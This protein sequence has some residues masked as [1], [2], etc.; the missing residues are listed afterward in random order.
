MLCRMAIIKGNYKFGFSVYKPTRLSI[1]GCEISKSEENIK[2]LFDLG[3][4]MI[5]GTIHFQYDGRYNHD[6]E[7]FLATISLAMVADGKMAIGLKCVHCW[8]HDPII[9]RRR[10]IPPS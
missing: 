7:K 5:E 8:P 10:K 4:H 1:S 9:E 3:I 6:T 2:A